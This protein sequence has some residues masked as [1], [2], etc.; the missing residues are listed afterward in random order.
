MQEYSESPCWSVAQSIVCRSTTVAWNCKYIIGR[1]GIIRWSRMSV[2]CISWQ[3]ARSGYLLLFT[4]ATTT[5]CFHI[6]NNNY[7]VCYSFYCC[8]LIMVLIGYFEILSQ[9]VEP[10]ISCLQWTGRPGQTY[11][12]GWRCHQNMNRSVRPGCWTVC[13]IRVRAGSTKDSEP[14]KATETCLSKTLSSLVPGQYPPPLTTPLRVHK[15]A[16]THAHAHAHTP[17]VVS[18]LSL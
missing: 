15:H 1:V 4:I 13:I 2:S 10:D 18:G 16:R 9:F 3:S 8:V 17:L 12:Q 11:F 14:L 5:W 7:N 6:T